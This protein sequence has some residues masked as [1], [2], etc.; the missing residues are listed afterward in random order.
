MPNG[1]LIVDK[2]QEWTSMDVCAKLRGLFQEKRIGHPDNDKE[3]I[4]KLKLGVVTNTQDIWGEILEEKA[5]SVNQDQFTALLPQFMGEIQQLPP[6]YSAVKIKGKRLYELARKGVEVEREPRPVVIHELEL[7]ADEPAR[8]PAPAASDSYCLRVLCS[9]GTYIRTLCHDIGQ[10]LGCGGCMAS[11]RQALRGLSPPKALGKA[12]CPSLP[13]RDLL[14]PR[15]PG[16]IP[17]LLPHRG[18]FG[19]VPG[20]GGHPVHDKNFF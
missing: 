10:A 14:H 15:R 18:V 13:R 4:S 17:G 7:L 9:K 1:I 5:V 16:G 20:G 19:S 12:S 8:C 3:Y 6:M 2:P 11:L